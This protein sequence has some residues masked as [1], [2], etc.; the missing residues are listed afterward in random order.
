MLRK[1]PLWH[2]S[3]SDC[4]TRCRAAH[5]LELS[6]VLEFLEQARFGSHSN[7]RNRRA[8]L[9]LSIGRSTLLL[10]GL[11]H[12]LEFVTARSTEDHGRQ[13]AAKHRREQEDEPSPDRWVASCIAVEV[14]GEVHPD[15][16]CRIEGALI[17]AFASQRTPHDR[18]TDSKAEVVVWRIVGGT[19]RQNDA[20]QRHGE[21][22]LQFQARA[23][24]AR[25]RRV[26]K[27]E[28]ALGACE[29]QEPCHHPAQDLRGHVQPSVRS[30]DLPTTTEQHCKRHGRVEEAA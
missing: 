12:G 15:G 8:E 19:R 21:E 24:G 9:I 11:G 23:P 3:C 1:S 20:A 5:L 2:L 30:R 29:G 27:A 6:N 13:D 17:D 10:R 28:G 16:D 7:R 22:H 4:R 18:T 26:I 14:V 25:E